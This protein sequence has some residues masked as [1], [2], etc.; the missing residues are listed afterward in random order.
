MTAEH[1]E[2]AGKLPGPHRDPWDRILIARADIEGLAVVTID[3][4]FADYKVPVVW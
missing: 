3:K 2:A 1:A 4:V